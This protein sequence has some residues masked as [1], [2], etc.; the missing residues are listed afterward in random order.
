MLFEKGYPEGEGPP[1]YIYIKAKIIYIK[2]KNMDYLWLHSHFSS[3]SLVFF[4]IPGSS[5]KYHFS[6]ISMFLFSNSLWQFL[7][8]PL[9][10]VFKSF[11]E[12]WLG[13]FQNAPQ[14]DCVWYFFSWLD[15]SYC[16]LKEYHRGSMLL[17]AGRKQILFAVGNYL[18]EM[19]RFNYGGVKEDHCLSK[20]EK[21]GV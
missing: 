21:T 13:V 20:Q 4:T 11:V 19:G 5:P 12:F 10:H 15:Q 9:F 18:L 1:W 16:F 6:F 14:L 3:C 17:E 2:A 7:G 8:L